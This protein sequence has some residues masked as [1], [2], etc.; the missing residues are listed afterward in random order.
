MATAQANADNAAA[1]LDQLLIDVGAG[2]VRR[3]LPGRPGVEF[4]ASLAGRPRKVGRRL[5]IMV[6]E[7]DRVALGRSAVE[8]KRGD[9]RFADPAWTHNPWLRRLV[10]AYLATGDAVAG[11]VDDAG[12]AWR[13]DQQIRFLAENIVEAISPSNVLMVNPGSAKAVIDT[14]GASIVRGA[15]A[16]V[17][18]MSS[19]PR[20]PRMVDPDALKPGRDLALTPGAVEATDALVKTADE[21]AS[22]VPVTGVLDEAAAQR[23]RGL[24]QQVL[25]QAS[26]AGAVDGYEKAS[27]GTRKP[28]RIWPTSKPRSRAAAR[29]TG[30][31]LPPARRPSS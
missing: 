5:S 26:A 1:P 6:G 4:T 30:R 29:L 8:P 2:P 9:R 3:W 23:I 18:D 28:C 19:S 27:T 7:L 11:L 17:R 25:D 16:F 14:G 15:R 10:Q 24:N 20:V 21:A 22:D 13:S 12:L 31:R